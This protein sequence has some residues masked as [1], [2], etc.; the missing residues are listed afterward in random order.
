MKGLARR[1]VELRPGRQL[2]LDL[3]NV[4]EAQ[5]RIARPVAA[6]DAGLVERHRLEERRDE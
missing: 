4:G 5:D 6:R 1:L 3:R 2:D